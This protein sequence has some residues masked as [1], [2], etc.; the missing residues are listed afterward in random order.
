MSLKTSVCASAPR[1]LTGPDKNADTPSDVATKPGAGAFALRLNVG[2]ESHHI[3]ATLT[4]AAQLF[5]VLSHARTELRSKGRDQAGADALVAKDAL[6]A[7]TQEDDPSD[8]AALLG[9]D[10]DWNWNVSET[11]SATASTNGLICSEDD[12]KDDGSF[13][14]SFDGSVDGS[15]DFDESL[16]LFD[17]GGDE[18]PSRPARTRPVPARPVPAR[19][20][21]QIPC[22]RCRGSKTRL[23]AQLAIPT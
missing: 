17:T 22:T 8:L 6:V 3:I 1:P 7:N 18:M 19:C 4:E 15:F 5:P 12:G 16:S 20:G 2:S 13:D 11:L 14:S 10:S 9:I 23:C 21:L